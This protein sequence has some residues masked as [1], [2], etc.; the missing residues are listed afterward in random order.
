MPLRWGNC[1]FYALRKWAREG[2]YLVIR[3][4]HHGWWP[5]FLWSKDLKTFE[6]F[7][8]PAPRSGLFLPPPVF[9][10]YVKTFTDAQDT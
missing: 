4:S 5:H 9:R 8:P 7:G 6:Q 1:L 3:K 2:G 10:G